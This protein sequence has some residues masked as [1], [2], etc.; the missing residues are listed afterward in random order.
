MKSMQNVLG[1]PG[2]RATRNFTDL[3]R[4][5]WRMLFGLI[6][7]YYIASGSNV[8]YSAFMIEWYVYYDFV[9]VSIHWGSHTIG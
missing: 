3:A 6:S 9:L 8:I 7:I 5:A 1:I 2:A 4:C